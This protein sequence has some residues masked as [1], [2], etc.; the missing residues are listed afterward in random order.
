MPSLPLHCQ[1]KD[2]YHKPNIEEQIDERTQSHQEEFPHEQTDELDLAR[3]VCSCSDLS[4]LVGHGLCEEEIPELRHHLSLADINLENM[5][6]V[7]PGTSG[8]KGYIK[9]M[10]SKKRKP[11]IEAIDKKKLKKKRFKRNYEVL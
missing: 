10:F 4:S 3:H 6:L 2:K 11:S 9:K 5:T 1:G 8:F 7:K